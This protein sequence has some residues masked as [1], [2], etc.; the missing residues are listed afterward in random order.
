MSIFHNQ[1]VMYI[2]DV[3]LR[4]KDLKRSL[5][6]YENVIGLNVLLKNGSTATLG[7]DGPLVTIVEDKNIKP[8]SR[9]A[10]LYHFA[11]LLPTRKD[12]ADFLMRIVKYQYQITGGSDHGVSEAIYL[13]DPDGN[14]IEIYHDRD[15]SQWPT[16]K[17]GGIDMFT[18]GLDYDNLLQERSPELISKMPKGTLMGHVHFH[19][20]SIDEA[21]HFF[22]E[23]IG[24]DV[25]LQYGPSALFISD[26]GYHHHVGLNVW[27]GSHVKNNV[28]GP[29][30][31]RYHLNATNEQIK[32]IK[33][34]LV[35]SN[36]PFSETSNGLDVVDINGVLINIKH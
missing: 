34:Q 27:L 19:V 32:H 29:G 13:D 9:H 16:T 28:D 12:L 5:D 3:T 30:L 2:K 1:E 6:F 35:Q 24:F 15:K 17:E 20:R 26:A 31:I 36:Y 22:T 18:E 33:Q 4:V 21:R 8:K 10:G 25:I 14:G 7:V 23:L 11:I